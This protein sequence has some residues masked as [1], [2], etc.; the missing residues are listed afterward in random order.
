MATKWIGQA[1][2]HSPHNSEIALLYRQ[3][4]SESVVQQMAR[5]VEERL[6]S[7]RSKFGKPGR[8]RRASVR[9]S[10]KW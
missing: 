9:C 7:D 3:I 1:R 6:E 10:A 4:H 2:K 8:R 5:V